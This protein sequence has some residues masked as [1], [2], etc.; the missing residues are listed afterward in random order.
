[1]VADGRTALSDLER[2]AMSLRD[3]SAAGV[4]VP[5]RHAARQHSIIWRWRSLWPA[6]SRPPP[7][8]SCMAV[9]KP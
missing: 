4:P 3:L 6:S 2:I 5:K 8:V 1:M 7:A 9:G